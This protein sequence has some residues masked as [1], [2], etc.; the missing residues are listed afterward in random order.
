MAV[1][2]A[3]N[4]RP[5]FHVKALSG[6]QD[7]QTAIAEPAMFIRQFAQPLSQSIIAL[8]LLLILKD[9]PVQVQ[10]ITRPTLRHAASHQASVIFV[11]RSSSAASTIIASANMRFSLL[12]SSSRARSVLASEAFMPPNFAFYLQKVASLIPEKKH[13]SW[14]LTPVSYLFIIPMICPSEIWSTFRLDGLF[15]P[16]WR[17]LRGQGQSAGWMPASSHSFFGAEFCLFASASIWLASIAICWPLTKLSSMQRKTVLSNRWRSKS[18]PRNL[19]CW[20]LET[21]ECSGSRSFRS[22]PQ[23]HRRARFSR[24]SSQSRR[25]ERMPK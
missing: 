17:D 12:F 4:Y 18:P 10:Q 15:P 1:C 25:Q 23:N 19:R 13:S 22:R 6:E 8:F 20:F 2:G 7:T 14:A 24:T 21:V 16:Q 5:V 3:L 11:A 9:G